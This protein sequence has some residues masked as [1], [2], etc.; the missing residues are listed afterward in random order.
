V[1]IPNIIAIDGP[2]AS[3]KST[4][5][6]LLADH[7]GYLYFD[8]G[9]MYRAVTL[10]AME[11]G[12][13][14]EDEE[15]ISNLAETVNIDV[16]PPSIEDGRMYDVLLD[17]KDVTWDIRRED[18]EVNVSPVSAYR[19]VRTALTEQQRR[20]GH[21]GKVVMVGRDIGTVV[22]PEAELKIYLEASPEERANRRYKEQFQRGNDVEYE[23]ILRSIQRRDQ[24]DS[25]RQVAPLKPAKDAI[26]IDTDNMDVDAVYHRVIS[27]IHTQK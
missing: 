7:L 26:T 25:T 15:T 4:L 19:G 20:I 5:A 24:I 9:I 11:S 22:L 27:I 10:A 18:V 12:Y 13:K 1:P 21:R 16:R 2:S 17:G 23:T 14:I 3:G 8:T 6:K